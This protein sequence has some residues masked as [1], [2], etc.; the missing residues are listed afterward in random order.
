MHICRSTL[1]DNGFVLDHSVFCD[2]MQT[3]RSDSWYHR[4]CN[5]YRSNCAPLHHE[6]SG[7][8][9]CGTYNARRNCRSMCLTGCNGYTRWEVKIVVKISKS[10][11]S[12]DKQSIQLS[13]HLRIWFVQL[14][15]VPYNIIDIN[16][17]SN[18]I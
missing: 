18:D 13:F 6:K 7:Q 9:K 15:K 4:S 17:I 11:H 1:S 16:C 8:I 5:C 2:W 14:Q 12:F 3:S 10:N